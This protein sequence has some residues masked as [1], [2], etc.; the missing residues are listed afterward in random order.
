M[1]YRDLKNYNTYIDKL[2]AYASGNNIK[3]IY[4]E[5]DSDGLYI[6]TRRTVV[7]DQD[8]DPTVEIAVFLHELGHSIDQH[9]ICDPNTELSNKVEKAYRAI[10][11]GKYTRKQLNIVLTREKEAWTC[12]EFIAKQLKIRLGK[13]YFDIRDSYLSS[14]KTA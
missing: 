2:N 6:P 4:R 9:L 1:C 10:Y 7:I 13:W 14:Y 11:K 8:L 3:V 5:E 12:G